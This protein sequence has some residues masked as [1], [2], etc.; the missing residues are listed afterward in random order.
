VN[1]PVPDP[2][3]SVLRR[4]LRWSVPVDDQW[5]QIGGGKVLHVDARSNGTVEVWTLEGSAPSVSRTVR[6]YGT[7][8]PIAEADTEHLG[9]VIVADGALVWHVFGAPTIEGAT[10]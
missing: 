4:A 7:G 5:H 1:A 2:S 9:S 10:S 8:H 3:L 6:V